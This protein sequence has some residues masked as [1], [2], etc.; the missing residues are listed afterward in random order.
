MEKYWSDDSYEVNRNIVIQK[1]NN[2]FSIAKSS[3]EKS[4]LHLGCGGRILPGF[5]NIDKY[6]QDKDV[7]NFD[8]FQ[9]PYPNNSIDVIY[10]SHVLEHL[11]IRHAKLAIIEWSRVL[12]KGG[13]LHLAIPDLEVILHKL[14]DPTLSEK[15]HQWMMYTLFGYQTNPANRDPSVLDFPI[16]PGQF[17]T[18]GFTKKT[19][20]KE[21]SNNHFLITEI[22][23]F[24]GWGT[25]SIWVEATL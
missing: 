22:F 4:Y 21:L 16:D 14:L 17:H 2:L 5:V 25:P 11:P 20:S 9:L 10:C 15:M 23:N 6:F 19:I 7:I 1:E 18:C 8:I 24:D 13:K 3:A 12:K